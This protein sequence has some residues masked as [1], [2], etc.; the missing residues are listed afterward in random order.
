M[1]KPKMRTNFYVDFRFI[2]ELSH[3]LCRE[4]VWQIC[5]RM[6]ERTNMSEVDVGAM[7]RAGKDRADLWRALKKLET[8]W[9]I[10]RVGRGWD[11][12][13]VNPE[14]YRPFFLDARPDKLADSIRAFKAVMPEVEVES[15]VAVEDPGKEQ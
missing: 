14:F 9:L 15:Q 5:S 10:R 12:V 3:R 8:L 6:D 7:I 11:R 13:W 1:G 4:L 2:V